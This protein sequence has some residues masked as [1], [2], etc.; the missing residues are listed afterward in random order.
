MR[1]LA[2]LLATV[3]YGTANSPPDTISS[4]I[5]LGENNTLAQFFSSNQIS[6]AMLVSIGFIVIN[7]TGFLTAI[8]LLLL[9]SL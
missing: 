8:F 4:A 9:G 6:N 1:T 2:G 7:F 5:D 3:A